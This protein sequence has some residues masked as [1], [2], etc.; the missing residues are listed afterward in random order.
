MQLRNTIDGYDRCR[1]RKIP[2][3][4]HHER[5]FYHPEELQQ[6][7]TLRYWSCGYGWL[8]EYGFGSGDMED[9]ITSMFL[10]SLFFCASLDLGTVQMASARVFTTFGVSQVEVEFPRASDPLTDHPAQYHSVVGLIGW[11]DCVRG[12]V[13]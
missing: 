5:T 4:P 8:E 10:D 9:W 12:T 6:G 2:S 11:Y 7:P 13:V 1:R 3:M